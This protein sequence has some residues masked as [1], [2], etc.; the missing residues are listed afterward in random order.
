MKVY[1]LSKLKRFLT[2]VNL[3]MKDSLETMTTKSMTDFVEFL[4]HAAR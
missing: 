3:M 1:E 2:M 4:E